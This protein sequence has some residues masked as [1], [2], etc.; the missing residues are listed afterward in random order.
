MHGDIV[1]AETEV[2][3]LLLDEFNT[4]EGVVMFAQLP[5]YDDFRE[6]DLPNGDELAHV[7]ETAYGGF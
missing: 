6:L 5:D 7:S 3:Q 1:N 2:N 4:E